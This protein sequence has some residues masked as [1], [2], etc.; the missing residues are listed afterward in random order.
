MRV[1]WRMT[2]NKL[3]HD[4]LARYS[5]VEF[6][7]PLNRLQILLA[8]QNGVAIEFIQVQRSL[9]PFHLTHV[10]FEGNGRVL[11][12]LRLVNLVHV[13]AT[14][15]RSGEPEKWKSELK[16][17]LNCVYSRKCLEDLRLAALDFLLAHEN[18]E[19]LAETGVAGELF[20]YRQH[21]QLL[22]TLSLRLVHDEL[23]Y[24][25]LY[26]HRIVFVL[27]VL[28]RLNCVVVSIP[29]HVRLHVDPI[30]R[31]VLDFLRAV[32]IGSLSKQLVHVVS[33]AVAVNPAVGVEDKRL[34]PG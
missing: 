24:R 1:G 32:A 7:R 17:L 16:E 25:H 14:R 33:V 30:H 31:S 4:V 5:L 9:H 22:E 20:V 2:V 34:D 27:S 21:F 26:H 10:D 8:P 11:A 13:G 3:H 18:H 6:Y 15:G 12:L 19:G 29:T 28:V 23:F